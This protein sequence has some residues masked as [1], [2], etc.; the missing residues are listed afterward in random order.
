MK[1][2]DDKWWF[3]EFG[4]YYTKRN[5]IADI[6]IESKDEALGRVAYPKSIR[7]FSSTGPYTLILPHRRSHVDGFLADRVNEALAEIG[8]LDR[9]F[10]RKKVTPQFLNSLVRFNFCYAFILCEVMSC[11]GIASDRAGQKGGEAVDRSAQRKWV[12]TLIKRRLDKGVL[13]Y[14]ADREVAAIIRNL[15]KKK[16]LFGFPEAWFQDLLTKGDQLKPAYAVKRFSK[17]KIE[18]AVLS[19]PKKPLPPTSF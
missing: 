5:E 11:D 16:Q 9:A 1:S 3:L 6:Y 4:D 7:P 19:K 10:K 15:I 8:E 17:V 2:F 18:A 14:K 12:G 13:R